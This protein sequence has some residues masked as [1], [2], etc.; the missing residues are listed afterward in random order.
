M[1]QRWLSFTV[2]STGGR[3]TALVTPC[4]ASA[5]FDPHAIP[6]SQYFQAIWD[7]GATGSVITQAVVDACGLKPIGMTVMRGVH[8]AATTE[9]YLVNFGLPNGVG[10]P[11]VTVVRGDLGTDVQ[12]LIGMD[13]I[14]RGDFAI[15][16][17]GGVTRF[18]FRFPSR[19]TI[20]FVTADGPQI[21]ARKPVL[22]GTPPKQFGMGRK[23]GK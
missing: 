11:N 17:V 20:D 12:I 10:I 2:T 16:N 9:K 1:S 18:S 13:I 7:T 22:G 3:L 21:A 19:N 5:A 15:T 8:G 4:A 14:T 6:E 23:R